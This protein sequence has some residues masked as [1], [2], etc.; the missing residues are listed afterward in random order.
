MPLRRV[1]T[2]PNTGV[3]YGPGSAAHHAAKCGAL[4]CVRGTTTLSSVRL[5][6]H[7]EIDQRLLVRRRIEPEN[8]VALADLLGDKILES[9]HLESLVG[10]LVGEMRRDHH[11]AVAV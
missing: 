3:L 7:G 5:P 1:G 11:H 4:R 6:P 2:V 9:G 8:A 10:D